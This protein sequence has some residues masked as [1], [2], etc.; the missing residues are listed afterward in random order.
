MLSALFGSDARVKILNFFLLAPEKKTNQR[1]LAASLG[2]PSASL[3]RELDNLLKIGLIKEVQLSWEE[4]NN[5]ETDEPALMAKTDVGTE[6]ETSKEKKVRST[7]KRIKP[8][9]KIGKNHYFAAAEEFILYPEIRDLFIKA[10]I[11]PGQKFLDELRK[12][13][14]LKLLLLTGTFTNRPETLTD[15]LI[16][17]SPPKRALA[18]FIAELEKNLGREINFTVLSEKEFYYRR[19]VMDL[20]L[21]NILEGK[22]IILF[23]HL[24]F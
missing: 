12:I 21:Y 4:V 1:Q 3:R 18:P 19:E 23:N 24:K 11:L 16:V 13:C 20:F 22:H 10:Q 14:Q 2:L 17:G 7:E 9:G 6:G 15:L 5:D 8:T